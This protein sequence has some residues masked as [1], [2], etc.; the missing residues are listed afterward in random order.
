MGQL[1]SPAAW[2]FVSQFSPLSIGRDGGEFRLG[3]VERSVYLLS[4]PS[5]NSNTSATHPW[6]LA[7]G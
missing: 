2:L 3:W 5:Q 7:Q 6:V 4:M 1:R